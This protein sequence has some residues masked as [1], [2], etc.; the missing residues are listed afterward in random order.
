MNDDDS[1]KIIDEIRRDASAAQA[2]MMVLIE[3]G[4]RDSA[5]LAECVKALGKQL[6]TKVEKA[7]F[8]PVKFLVYSLTISI[9]TGVIGA[10]LSKVI[11]K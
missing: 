6:E 9:L 11:M 3:I 4:R 8:N 10:F 1:R 2:A 5:V 7:E